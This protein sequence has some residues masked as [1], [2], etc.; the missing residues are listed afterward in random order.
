MWSKVSSQWQR[1]DFLK[2]VV[3]VI[4]PIYIYIYIFFLTD[5][6]FL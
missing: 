4:E 5:V 6:C 1:P 3:I 2:I